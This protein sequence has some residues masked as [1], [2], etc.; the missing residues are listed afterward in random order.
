VGIIALYYELLTARDCGGLLLTH[1]NVNAGL[2][3]ARWLIRNAKFIPFAVFTGQHEL[4]SWEQQH[5]LKQVITDTLW[6]CPPN[7]D[8]PT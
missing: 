4:P 2:F 3:T 8:W 6:K 5:N 1:S 7:F